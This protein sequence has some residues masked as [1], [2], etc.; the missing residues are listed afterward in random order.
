MRNI[1]AATDGSR[2]ANRALIAAAQLAK[3]TGAE[4]CILS[5]GNHLSGGKLKQLMRVESDVGEALELL[6]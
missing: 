6:S 5:V 3:A 4:L 2:G 1:V